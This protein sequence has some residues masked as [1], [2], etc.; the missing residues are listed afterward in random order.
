MKIKNPA[1]TH[2]LIVEDDPLAVEMLTAILG[3]LAYSVV[4][5]AINGYQAIEMIETLQPDVVLMD[6]GLPGI[7]GIEAARRIQE[8]R[9]TPVIILTAYDRSDL[10]E[11]AADAG[12]GAYL[13]KPVTSHSL[14]NA[15]TTVLAR[16]DDML[17]LRRL[18]VRLQ[19]EVEHRQQLEE[20]HA[21]LLA[22]ER[23]QRLLAETL[24][25]ITLALT[26]QTD[27]EAI[28][29][30]I[31]SQT[32]RIISFEMASIFRLEGEVL[33]A[34]RFWGYGEYATFMQHFVL[35]LADF[36]IMA[37]VVR[38]Q[39]PRVIFDVSQEPDWVIIDEIP[40]TKSALFIPLCLRQQV[41]GVFI[42]DSLRP[43]AFTMTDADR[44][45]P[46]VNAAAIAIENVELR[47]DLEAEVAAR[48]AE[49]VAERDKSNAILRSTGDA[50]A[51]LDKDLAI[52][53]VNPA[54]ER[55]TGYT[56][57]EVLGK[58]IHRII[59]AEL[60]DQS[61]QAMYTA[62]RT[63]SEWRGEFVASRKDGRTYDAMIVITPILQ[64]A[65][66]VLGYVF[67]HQDISPLKALARAR[68]QF[69]TG[70]S[71]ELRTP[72]TILDLTLQ[73]LRRQLPP[74]MDLS[75]VETIAQQIAQLTHFTEDILAMAALDSGKA[76]SQWAPLMLLQLVTDMVRRYQ[77]RAQAAGLIL[78]WQSA[79]AALPVVYGDHSWVVR[80]IAEIIENA[81]HFT[82]A[83][84]SITVALRSVVQDAR[85]WLT[86]AVRDT[87]PGLTPEECERVFER[88]YRGRLAESGH[89]PG[90]GL[91]LSIAQEIARAHGGSI[92]V[93]STPGEG[94]TF[95]IWLP[96][97]V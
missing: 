24:A 54:F 1:D 49:I 2:I 61:R 93:E 31:L 34:V 56:A 97:V 58:N 51:M 69:I 18:N 41:L 14:Q 36:P 87:G 8:V 74:D 10:V 30:E 90:C 11:Q 4:G 39:K 25:E 84:G 27:Y 5:V 65:G 60:S 44:L 35:P 62:Y 68:N 55:L 43:H 53:Y 94:S 95:T 47:R 16:F 79:E 23:E 86:I 70:I 92:T 19:S 42:L 48:T 85:A 32:A 72:L 45:A 57:T 59:K 7:D 28:L 46:L 12:V 22:V 3:D 71:H 13:L 91:G 21:R 33:R 76:I 77:E 63:A 38:S 73:K 50:I 52:Q 75:A 66:D 20:D 78:T 17:E 80:M 67:C 6:I 89:I 64:T 81:L 40:L 29:D 15:I 37:E 26:S 83:G 82:P 96:A 88:F 9:S